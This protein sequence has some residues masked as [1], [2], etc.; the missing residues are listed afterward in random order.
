[1]KYIS[2]CQIRVGQQQQQA[3]AETETETEAE[4]EIAAHFYGFLCDARG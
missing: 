4:T 2:H 1:M 3:G